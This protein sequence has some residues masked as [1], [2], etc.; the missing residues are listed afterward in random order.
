MKDRDCILLDTLVDSGKSLSEMALKLHKDGARRI[1]WFSPHGLFTDTS[2]KLIKNS[3]I[4]EC[5][6]TNTVEEVKP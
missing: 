4:E 1:F 5:I 6:V 3:Y 2:Q